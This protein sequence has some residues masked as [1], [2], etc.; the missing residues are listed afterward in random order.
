M[1]ICPLGRRLEARRE[2]D[3][4]FQAT[5]SSTSGRS[6]PQKNE[7]LNLTSITSSPATSPGLRGGLPAPMNSGEDRMTFLILQRP[8][9]PIRRFIRISEIRNPSTNISIAITIL[10]STLIQMEGAP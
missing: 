7:T 6:S 5:G 8:Q 3:R 9:P 1:I 10:S 2:E 4:Q